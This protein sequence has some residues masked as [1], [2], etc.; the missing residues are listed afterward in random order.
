M[1]A[2]LLVLVSLLLSMPAEAARAKDV[3]FFYGLQDNVVTGAGL[4]TGLPRSGDSTRN[5]AS[6]RALATRLQGY[7]VTFSE[8]ELSSRNIAMVMVTAT[9]PPG[10]RAGSA[11]DVKVSSSGDAVSIEGGELLMTPLYGLDGRIHV[12]ASGAVLVGG[13][14]AGAAG[15]FSRKGV[16]TSGLVL[17]GGRLQVEVQTLDYNAMSIVEFV[18]SKPDF[19]TAERLETAI[20]AEFGEGTARARTSSTIEVSVP[21]DYNDRFAPF[22]ARLESVTLSVDSAATIV[23]DERTG[24]VVFGANVSV[25]PVAI[26]HGA[27][28]IEVRKIN[29]VSQPSA[30]SGGRTAAVSNSILEANEQTGQLVMVEG[31]DIGQLVSALNAMGVTPRDLISILKN[32]KAQGAIH[33]EVITQ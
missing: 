28:T 26:A 29:A 12:L 32:M 25:A 7:G 19:T 2:L 27:L 6:I 23:V 10:A 5:E 14:A 24:T 11:V 16:P 13:Y 31:V 15:N 33:A 17:S 21:E 4:V 18:L 3:G 22:A 9:I 30:F 1:H 8:D 20:N